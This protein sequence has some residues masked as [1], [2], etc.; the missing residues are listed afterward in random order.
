MLRCTAVLAVLLS[1]PGVAAAQDFGTEWLDRVL[2]QYQQER[3]PQPARPYSLEVSGGAA[4]YFDNNIFLTEDDEEKSSVI[5]PF[6]RAKFD[7]AAH[8]LDITA[9]LLANYRFY[10][11]DHDL[12]DDEE[13]FYLHIRQVGSRH[14]IEITELLQHVSD[15]V[16]AVFFERVDRIVS[17][18]TPK[19][20]YDMTRNW[21]VELRGDAQAVRYRDNDTGDR[22]DNNNYRF[23]ASILWRSFWGLDLLAQYGYF[24]VDYV[25][26]QGNG[27]PPDAFGYYYRGGVRGEILPSLH[28]EFFA[29]Y[30][31]VESDFVRGTDLDE[32]D[33]DLDVSASLRYEATE[34]FRIFVDY[35][36]LF[37]FS[38]GEDP[39]QLIN[40]GVLIL[41]WQ[42]L[43]ELTIRARAQADRADTSGGQ[44]REYW[45]ASLSGAYVF[46]AH[47]AVDAGV[48]FRDGH[49]VYDNESE[50]DW[51]A[52]ILHVGLALT[53]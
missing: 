19:L 24:N 4:Y 11:T 38:G 17:T 53:W 48:A 12:D 21:S 30:T 33:D 42:P 32:D 1:V 46:N 20:S 5:I 41:E 43:E 37:T 25:K 18:T 44:D 8:D 15:P 45:S 16:D 13:R 31:W 36:R 26:G 52:L 14:S 10:T 50:L 34:T 39:F 6:V 47:I 22:F 7:Y 27:A 40:R 29:G 9:D 2:H 49:T 35:S 23:D 3:G 51:D 28:A